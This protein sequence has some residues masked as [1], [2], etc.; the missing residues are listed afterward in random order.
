MTEQIDAAIADA[1]ARSVALA[2]ERAAKLAEIQIAADRMNGD[3]R[4]LDTKIASVSG[5]LDALKKLKTQL[6]G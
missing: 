4:T 6:A 1:E 5:E 3:L 2:N